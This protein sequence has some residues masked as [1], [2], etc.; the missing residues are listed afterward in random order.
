MVELIPIAAEEIPQTVRPNRGKELLQKFLSID[1]SAA[2]VKLNNGEK[3]HSM[4]WSLRRAVA[5]AG[6]NVVVKTVN[7]SIYLKRA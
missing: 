7:G 6:V 3:S 2:K 4:A 1:G 5:Q